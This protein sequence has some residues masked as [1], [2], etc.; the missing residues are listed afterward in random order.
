MKTIGI[1]GGLGPE[2]TVAYYQTIIAAFNRNG[3][4]PLAY[5]EI[6]VHSA[7][8]YDLLA[9]IERSDW[10]AIADWLLTKLGG[11][12]RAGAEFAAIAS[13]T[14]HIVFDQVAKHS[15]LPLINIVEETARESR[16]LGFNKLGLLGT[17][18]T[19]ASELYRTPFHAAGMTIHAPGPDEQRRIHHLLFSEIELGIFKESTRQELLDIAQR[20][21]RE[22]GIEA[23]ILGCTEL[24]LILPDR[25]LGMP[26]LNTTAIH[27][28]AIVEHCLQ[29]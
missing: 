11:L 1:I 17:R 6:I 13:N 19:M 10:D 9:L 7:N 27:C 18:L 16:R 5:P 8:L 25:A 12:Q 21:Q 14:P 23:L 4:A 15:P 20:L 24:P 29:D 26:F 2:S 3:Q 28:R 22:E